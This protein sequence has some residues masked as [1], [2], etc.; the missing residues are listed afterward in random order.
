[1]GT[2]NT[3]RA[4]RA[5][6]TALAMLVLAAATAHAKDPNAPA[7]KKDAKPPASTKPQLSAK[8]QAVA[9]LPTPRPPTPAKRTPASFTREMSFGEA[10]DILRNSTTPPLNIVVLWKQIEENAGVYR[11][12]PIGMDGVPGL[13]VRQYLELLLLSVSGGNSAKLGYIVH[14]GVV[15]VGMA[16]A[17]PAP[18][19]V[20]R[21]Y[22]ISDLVAPPSRPF[23]M[24]MG[25]GGI[26]MGSMGYGGTYGP[27]IGTGYF[28]PMGQPGPYRSR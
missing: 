25:F 27:G 22:D 1:M 2:R 3:Q 18:K 24:P 16:D 9:K 5:V 7:S 11:E 13:R 15:T 12:T 10:I 14:N 23:L 21:I 19:R 17:L 6:T 4:T 28:G 26:G 8:S 20:T